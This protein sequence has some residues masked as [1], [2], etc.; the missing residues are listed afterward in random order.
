MQRVTRASGLSEAEQAS[1]FCPRSMLFDVE[2]YRFV[3]CQNA[4][5]PG[6]NLGPD[7]YMVKFP[8]I[9]NLN[10]SDPTGVIF[11]SENRNLA[12]NALITLPVGMFT[13]SSALTNL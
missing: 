8:I 4:F 1:G 9:A 5:A 10:P 6:S 2:S 13:G 7:N 3:G 11:P 12:F